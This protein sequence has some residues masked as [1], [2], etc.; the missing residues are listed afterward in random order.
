MSVWYWLD[1]ITSGYIWLGLV[2][3]VYFWLFHDRLG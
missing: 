2:M 3:Y 1:H